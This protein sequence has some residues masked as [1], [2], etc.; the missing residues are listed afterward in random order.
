[1]DK[2]P[3]EVLFQKKPTIS[4][5]RLFYTRCYVH[6]PEESR[7]AGCKLDARALEGHLIGYME[8]TCMFRV[9]IPSQHKVDA[10]RQV[11][12]EPS[13]DTSVHLHT[14]R[15]TSNNADQQILPHD[16]ARPISPSDQ[17]QSEVTQHQQQTTTQSSSQF[18]GSYPE[19]LVKPSSSA[20]PPLPLRRTLVPPESPPR[21]SLDYTRD[22][23][24]K[25]ER[26]LDDPLPDPSTPLHQSTSTR[27]PVASKSS[28][29]KEFDTVPETPKLSYEQRPTRTMKPVQHYSKYGFARLVAEPQSYKETM[30]SL[31]SDV[32]QHAMMEEHQAIMDTGI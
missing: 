6:I 17:L 20:L 24:S 21:D 23:D 22:S 12:F 15:P 30:A 9:Y 27:T 8:T 16:H 26:G 5:L 18:P 14:P 32:W 25:S 28:Q 19:T 29:T 31:D 2:T 13:S 1:M 4:H 11:R 3:Y 10:Y 7:A